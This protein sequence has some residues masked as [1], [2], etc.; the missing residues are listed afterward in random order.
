MSTKY[1]LSNYHYCKHFTHS[2]LNRNFHSPILHLMKLRTE[3]L[4]QLAYG[5]TTCEGKD[6]DL[7]ITQGL[8][9]K[10]RKAFPKPQFPPIQEEN[11]LSQETERVG[12]RKGLESSLLNPHANQVQGQIGWNVKVHL[13]TKVLSPMGFPEK[14]RGEWGWGNGREWTRPAKMGRSGLELLTLG[15]T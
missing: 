15:C 12:G 11:F 1:F 6:Q 5:H 10:R 13:G 2:Y 8:G 4:K 3:G 9:C 7:N 14:Y